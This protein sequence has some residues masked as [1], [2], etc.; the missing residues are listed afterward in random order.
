MEIRRLQLVSD[1]R[2][3]ACVMNLDTNIV[4]HEVI[5][6]IGSRYDLCHLLT[7]MLDDY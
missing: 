6:R 5:K 2:T 3:V 1:E 7:N 4:R